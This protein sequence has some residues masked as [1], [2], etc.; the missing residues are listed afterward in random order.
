MHLDTCTRARS[1]LPPGECRESSRSQVLVC[2]C[3]GGRHS[4]LMIQVCHAA[5]HLRLVRRAL[6]MG[7]D[8]VGSAACGR[9]QRQSK[10]LANCQWA[11]HEKVVQCPEGPVFTADR[12]GTKIPPGRPSGLAV[13]R[14]T[15]IVSQND[16]Q[17]RNRFAESSFAEPKNKFFEESFCETITVFLWTASPE[18]R[19]GGI[20]VPL[21]SA[22]KTGPSGH[23]TTFS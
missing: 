2:T 21:R 1:L 12:S 9:F 14:K 6:C 19:P 4:Q 7:N 16:A 3:Y 22:V 13:Q 23:W 11:C 8:H 18:G 17:N 10:V 15:V 20:L 5:C